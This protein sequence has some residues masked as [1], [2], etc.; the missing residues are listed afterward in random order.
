MKWVTHKYAGKNSTKT[1]RG[2]IVVRGV[3]AMKPWGYFYQP[4]KKN[5]NQIFAMNPVN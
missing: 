4:G 2:A 5:P 1:A 3:M